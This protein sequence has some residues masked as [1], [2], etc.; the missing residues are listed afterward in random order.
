VASGNETRIPVVIGGGLTDL[1]GMSLVL[2]GQFGKFLGAEKGD[3][4]QSYSTPVM[5]MSRTEER[6]VYVDFA[7]MGLEA[8]GLSRQG[9]VVVLRFEGTP[10][11]RLT[12]NVA[13]NSMNATLAVTKKAGEGESMP[14]IYKLSQNYPNPFNP[15]TMIEYEIPQSGEVSLEVYNILGEKIATL[16]N[17]VKEAGFYTV[18]WNGKDANQA[19]VASGVYFYRVHAGSFSSVKKM[20]LLK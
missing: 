14:T 5:V 16:V 11:V 6:N 12:A 20:M 7:V 18:Q 8:S 1:R 9:E 10:H 19:R 4:L 13:R 17:E 2:N 3:L 15:T